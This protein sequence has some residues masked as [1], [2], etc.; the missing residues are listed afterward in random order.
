MLYS[1]VMKRIDDKIKEVVSSHLENNNIEV[2]PDLKERIEHMKKVSKLEDI[3]T[4]MS[5]E[6]KKEQ[7]A[8]EN[9]SKSLI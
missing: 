4:L 2:D 9:S 6:H 3:R 8:L 1:D 7:E 5:I